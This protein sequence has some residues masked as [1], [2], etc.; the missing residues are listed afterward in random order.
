MSKNGVKKIV[1]AIDFMLSIPESITEGF[2]RNHFKQAILSMPSDRILTTK[3]IADLFHQLK[4][5]GYIEITKDSNGNESLR[6]TNKSRL[7]VV[8]QYS[9]RAQTDNIY[10]FVSFDIPERLRVNRNHFRRIIKRLGFKQ[11]QKSLWV[12]NKEIGD[13][14]EIAA[15]EYKIYDYIVYLTV[16]K[17]NIDQV[18][19]K[20]LTVR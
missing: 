17:T 14:V 19:N 8:D 9:K 20:I 2:A 13:L 16:S 1:E 5:S 11:I 4:R 18:I 3:N 10:K 7:A 15:R 6:F 12:S